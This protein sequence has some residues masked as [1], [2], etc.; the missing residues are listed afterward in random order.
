MPPWIVGMTRHS[1]MTKNCY[2][3]TVTMHLM[4]DDGDNDKAKSFTSQVAH[5]AGAYLRFL[6]C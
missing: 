2:H 6:Y 1:E 4:S 3:L 5:G